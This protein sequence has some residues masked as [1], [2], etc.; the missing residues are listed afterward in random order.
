MESVETEKEN[1]E[2]YDLFRIGVLIKAGQGVIELIASAFVFFIPVGAITRL[3]DHFTEVE[4]AKDPDDFI[5]NHLV[6]AAHS[7]S[8]GMKDFAALYLFLSGAIKLALVFALLSGNR[9]AFPV[10]LA[11]FGAFILY[12]LYRVWLHH[13]P[14]LALATLLDMAVFYFIW[15]EYGVVRKREAPVA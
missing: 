3:A 5:A 8:I 1:A 14:I 11:V 13:S 4:L 12:L 10:A 9:R 2:L 15:R 7:I 6:D